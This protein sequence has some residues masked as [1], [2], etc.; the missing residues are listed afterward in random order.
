MICA[1]MD[2]E[3]KANLAYTSRSIQGQQRCLQNPLPWTRW[4]VHSSQPEY[5][6]GME[7]KLMW[8]HGKCTS[9]SYLL[10]IPVI[11]HHQSFDII[12]R[13]CF[14]LYRPTS[15]WY[16]HVTREPYRY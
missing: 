9:F 5:V 14:D 6:Q 4:M 15:V 10:Y 11:N 7:D 3:V 1:W 16:L 13:V 2:L 8:I 12:V